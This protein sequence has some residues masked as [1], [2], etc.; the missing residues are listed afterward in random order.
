[1]NGV[2][3]YWR[4]RG[5]GEYDPPRRWR[6]APAGSNLGD[7]GVQMLDADGDGRGST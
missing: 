2:V 1:M 5:N 6:H 7:A 3:R 4:N